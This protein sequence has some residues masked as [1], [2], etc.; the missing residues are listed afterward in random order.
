MRNARSR[1][2]NV[3]P[4]RPFLSQGVEHD[5]REYRHEDEERGHGYFLFVVSSDAARLMAD[6]NRRAC[7]VFSLIFWL[8]LVA[9]LISCC[10]RSGILSTASMRNARG[11]LLNSHSSP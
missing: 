8:V 1:Q 11:A 10:N 4:E 9:S 5:D 7:S 2:P 3:E 6:A